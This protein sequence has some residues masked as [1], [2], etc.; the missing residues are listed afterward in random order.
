MYLRRH[1]LPRTLLRTL[2]VLVA[3]FSTLEVLH[4]QRELARAAAESSRLAYIAGSERLFV[5]AIFWNNEDILRTSLS[6]ALL[7]LAA[8]VGPKN[9]FV[10]VHESGSWDG[11]K[12]ALRDLDDALGRAGVERK[13]STSNVTHEDE[14]SAEPAGDGWV[15]TPQGAKELRRIPY[16][17]GQRNV[18]LQPL[19]DMAGQGVHF[20]KV[21]FVNDVVFQTDDALRLLGTNGG[22]YGAACSMDYKAPPGF[23]DTFALRDARGDEHVMA[24]WP[25]F[26]ARESR[27]AVL[28][29][30]DVPVK[31]CWNGMGELLYGSTCIASCG[32]FV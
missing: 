12:D 26:R 9:V 29:M 32:L 8:R 3:L 27:E 17:A 13:I 10:S 30:R 20:D 22:S 5:T 21:L 19:V 16:L 11:T 28:G 14:V 31:S 6:A 24:T 15:V 2:V 7:D 23:Y 18:A 1:N 25:F 4:V